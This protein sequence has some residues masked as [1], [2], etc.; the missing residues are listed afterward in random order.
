MAFI[1]GGTRPP[2][3]KVSKEMAFHMAGS[4]KMNSP[5]LTF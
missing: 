3:F 5:S 1:S 2:E 4:K